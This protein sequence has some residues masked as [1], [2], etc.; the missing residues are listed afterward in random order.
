VSRLLVTMGS[1]PQP[2]R[3]AASSCDCWPKR[4]RQAS[5][6]GD[7][8]LP[9]NHPVEWPRERIAVRIANVPP[10]W[11]RS[12]LGVEELSRLEGWKA[13]GGGGCRYRR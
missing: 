7:S 5:T 3:A 10:C 13:G 6:T 11:M 12:G 1:G 2:R 9:R 4:C 8:R